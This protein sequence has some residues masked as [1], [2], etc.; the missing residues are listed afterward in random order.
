MQIGSPR[1]RPGGAF[2]AP[3]RFG[4]AALRPVA[5][6]MAVL[7]A[8]VLVRPVVAAPAGQ[9]PP[10]PAMPTGGDAAAG[11]LLGVFTVTI[12]EADIPTSLAG[13][14]AL[15]GLWTVAFNADGTYTVARQDV[16]TVVSG[17]FETEG[18]TLTFNDW[19]GL[20]PCGAP[21][22]AETA[23]SYGWQ[24]NGDVLT[25][26]PIEEPCAERRILLGTRAFGSFEACAVQPMTA[27]PLGL[28]AGTPVPGATPLA[29]PVGDIPSVAVQEGLPQGATPEEAIDALLRQGTGCWATQDPTR[30]LPLHSQKVFA[31]LLEVGPL[32][33]VARDLQSFMATPVSFE[34]IGGVN[35]DEAGTRAWAYVEITFGGEAIPQRMDFVQESGAWL[36]DTFFLF[37]PSTP[38]AEEE[39]E[40][41]VP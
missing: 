14:P 26:T 13:G 10:A 36:F 6:A 32:P 2:P 17:T 7:V 19:S 23:A 33:D 18:G 4:P 31:E 16:G 11:D 8:W 34:R 1:R 38:P 35:L 37:G 25:M 3:G 21:T 39:L 28:E 30:F 12:G 20:I 15:R 40:V 41:E 5:L 22:A 24:R 9:T 27:L 29:T